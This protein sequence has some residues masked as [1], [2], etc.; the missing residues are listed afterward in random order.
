SAAHSAASSAW[1]WAAAD[2]GR[3]RNRQTSRRLMER[4][5]AWLTP[6]GPLLSGKGAGPGVRKDSAQINRV[7]PP[8]ICAL[9]PLHAAA[10][11]DTANPTRFEED[12]EP[13]A[14]RDPFRSRRLSRLGTGPA[15]P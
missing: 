11:L 10:M 15:V 1:V 5:P 13:A 6:H 8:L 4:A 12:H 14:T 9:P 7:C 2:R 3:S